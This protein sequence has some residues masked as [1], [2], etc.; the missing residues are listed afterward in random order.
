MAPPLTIDRQ[1]A[2]ELRARAQLI[3]VAIGEVRP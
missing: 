2:R 3:E 1:T